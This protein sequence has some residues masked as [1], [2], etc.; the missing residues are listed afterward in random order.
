LTCPEAGDDG[1][2]AIVFEPAIPVRDA[3]TDM[4]C[5]QPGFPLPN[6]K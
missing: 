5:P 3:E 4:R 1:C 6:G 2:G